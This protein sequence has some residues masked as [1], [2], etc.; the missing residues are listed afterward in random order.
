MRRVLAIVSIPLLVAGCTISIGGSGDEPAAP[1]GA[2]AGAP[3][4]VDD[5]TAA[6]SEDAEAATPAPPASEGFALVSGGLA[7]SG[8]Q[9]V[10]DAAA[11]GP[12]VVASLFTQE[13]GADVDAGLAFSTDGG[14]TWAWGGTLAQPGDQ[15]ATGALIEPEG[16]ILVG[17][18]YTEDGDEELAEAFVAL[19]LAPEFVP[20]AADL[21]EEF[22][23][24]D[25][26]LMDMHNVNGEWIIVGYQGS[27]PD[28]DGESDDTPVLW[29]SADEGAT[30]TKQRIRVAGS[31]DT[32]VYGMV[33]APDGSWNL[34]GQSYPDDGNGFD[35]AWLRSTDDGASFELVAPGA[36][37]APSDQ[38]AQQIV[39][40]D[41][42]AVAVRGWDELDEADDED[43]SAVWA[44]GS[45]EEITRLGT[46]TLAVA[47]GT[48]PGSFLSGLLFDA[49]TLVAW[50]SPDGSKPSDPVQFWRWEDGEFV[51]SSTIDGDG[52][53]LSVIRILTDDAVA[54]AFG[55]VSPDGDEAD[56][57]VWRASLG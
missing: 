31:S 29:R 48:P 52:S 17:T 46:Q 47:G 1:A 39:F 18:T 20:E 57:G 43:V 24:S 32:P 7:A 37:S 4:A 28:A 35:A 36:F 12:T 30:W 16:V 44:A 8:Y 6:P 10:L 25:V 51:P 15:Y 27:R 34:Y 38:G 23:G 9:S 22:A 5:P 53:P 33:V 21:P 14:A 40:D 54:L 2:T 19:A 56:A 41:T 3:S 45:G 50:G 42:G 11:S 13:D 49:D 55:Y 26:H